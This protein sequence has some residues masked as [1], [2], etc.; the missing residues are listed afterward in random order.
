MCEYLYRIFISKLSGNIGYSDRST[1]M[2]FVYTTVLYYFFA[3][4]YLI[5]MDLE[6]SLI[7]WTG[8]I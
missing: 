7:V 2:P 6:N 5:N 3:R 1:D 4:F 8:F